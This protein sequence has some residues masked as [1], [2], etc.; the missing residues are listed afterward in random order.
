MYLKPYAAR[1]I[2]QFAYGIMHSAPTIQST[3]LQ[4]HINRP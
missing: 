2:Y 3:H 1:Y 4:L